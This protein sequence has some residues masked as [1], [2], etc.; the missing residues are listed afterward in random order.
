MPWQCLPISKGK[1]ADKMSQLHIYLTFN[2]NCREAMNFYHTCFGGE[3]QLQTIGDSPLG[4]KLDPEMRHYILH[5][6]ISTDQ[7]T[8]LG[9]DM[10]DENDLIQGNS[11]SIWVECNA[12][13]EVHAY[14]KKLAK[15]GK[16]FQPIEQTFSGALLGSLTDQ[17]GK[18]WIFHFKNN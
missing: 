15:N 4:N 6:S 10:V 16:A 7:F 9:T 3:V 11:V 2:G 8:L 14:Y 1:E 5:A 18:H 17:F 13:D 12:T